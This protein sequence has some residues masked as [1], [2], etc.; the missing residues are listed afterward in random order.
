MGR[1]RDEVFVADESCAPADLRPGG[2][3]SQRIAMPGFP[4]LLSDAFRY[5]FELSSKAEELLD[6]P[7]K[8]LPQDQGS[9]TQCDTANPGE[10]QE[11]SKKKYG[12]TV[13]VRAAAD[14]A[15]PGDRAA[16]AGA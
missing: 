1:Y 2:G 6:T 9:D 13:T 5:I 16:A 15:A 10:A 4:D 12:R 3:L 14:R 8:A 11:T 7:V